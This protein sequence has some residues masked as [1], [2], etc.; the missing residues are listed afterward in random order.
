[1]R[2][3]SLAMLTM[4]V[5]GWVAPAWPQEATDPRSLVGK[6]VWNVNRRDTFVVTIAEV[7]DDGT[8]KGTYTF[9]RTSG[10]I[11]AKVTQEGDALKMQFGQQVK[12]DLTYDKKSDSLRGPAT[13]WEPRLA[14]EPDY[15]TAYFKR[16][17]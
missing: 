13:G 14:K 15:Q 8:V 10:Q 12:F 16:E 17:K 5:L 6:W 9:P 3:R 2:R 7:A 4:I 11:R 1:M